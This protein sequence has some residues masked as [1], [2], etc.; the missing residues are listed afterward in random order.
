MQMRFETS[1]LV[2]T[3][4]LGVVFGFIVGNIFQIVL[5]NGWK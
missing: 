4:I 1:E 3:F 5:K 2:L